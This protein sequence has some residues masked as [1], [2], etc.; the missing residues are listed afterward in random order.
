L[1]SASSISVM[2]AARLN[3]IIEAICSRLASEIVNARISTLYVT[4][5]C[6]CPLSYRYLPVLVMWT[7][8]LK[9]DHNL[10]GGQEHSLHPRQERGCLRVSR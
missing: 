1:K 2:P 3:F 5:P 6:I 9:V 10:F 8:S 7:Q 4:Y